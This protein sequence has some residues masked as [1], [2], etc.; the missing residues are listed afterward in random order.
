MAAEARPDEGLSGL[1]G[2]G[3]HF[4]LQAGDTL[5]AFDATYSGNGISGRLVEGDLAFTFDLQ[6]VPAYAK[7]AN[8]AEAWKQDLGVVRG[9]FLE[10][11]R[12][13]SPRAK[14]EFEQAID[15]LEASLPRMNDQQV[16]VALSEA[17]AL[18][19][20]AH[21]RLYLL[22]NRTELRRLPVRLYW[23]SDGLFVIRATPAH[24]DTV[25][26]RMTRLA[27][28]DP[29]RIRERVA[30][31]FAGNESWVD[32]KSPYFMTSPEIL[33]G[34]GAIV[35]MEEVPLRF[36]CDGRKPFERALAPLPLR[37]KQTPTE[38]W[39]DLS[40]RWQEND[41]DGG[42]DEG[43]GG[44][45]D[46]GSDW[47]GALHDVEPA[48]LYLR[49]PVRYYWFEYLDEYK[50]L[51]LQYN[52][53]QNIPEGASFEEFAARLETFIGKHP[54][55]MFILDLRFN[56]GGNNGIAARFME[57][58]A[59]LEKAGTIGRLYVITGR[60]TFSAG[61]SH[62]AWLK[63]H[64]DATFVG[65]PI[66]DELDTWSEGGN[67]VLPNSGLTVHFTNGFHSLSR[68]EHPELEKYEWS[69][70]DLDDIDPDIPVRLSSRDYFAGRDPVLEAILPEA[71]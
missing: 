62:A 63:Q 58:L 69:D 1:A 6:K 57:R 66:G 26:C 15:A 49:D 30:R 61:I 40:P 32:Y 54:I 64:S 9:R 43:G 71:D 28:R 8:R 4:E 36:D 17:V 35:D 70:L 24:R 14:A 7:P 31:L 68:V 3:L 47:V 41:G 45:G 53:S 48:P 25:G 33:Y 44:G 38:A 10:Y 52:R 39:R 51:Y 50:A 16:I 21:T 27:G 11:D 20:N 55:G 18:S 29:R 65:E 42:S 19:G 34:I 67:I 12:S 22:R 5:V 2:A 59:V 37:R 56:T 13:F 60:A 46:A 23:F